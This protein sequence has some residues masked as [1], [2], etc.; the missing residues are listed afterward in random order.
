MSDP[1]RTAAQAEMF[2]NRLRKRFRHLRRWA[3]REGI[4]CFR[5]YDREIPE[6]PI[7]VDWY[8]GR[9]H[10]SVFVG[11]AAIHDAAWVD[12]M[13]ATAGEVLE[14]PPEARFA[15]IRRPQ[16]KGEQGQYERVGERG[17][18]FVVREAG[19]AFRVNLSDYVDTGLFLDH[20]RLRARV[21]DEA[22]GRDMLN[23]FAY[24]GGFSVY[25]AAGGARSTT[26]V[27]LSNTYLDWAR[28][29]LE[30]NGFRG[31][32]HQFVRA[33]VEEFVTH[34]AERQFDLVVVDPPTFSNSKRMR[35]VLDLRRDHPAL[36]AHVI[37]LVRPGGVVYF[38]TNARRFRLEAPA[39]AA[40]E[41]TAETVSPDFTRHHSH[42]AW[43]ITRD[44]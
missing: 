44:V 17:A 24:T 20:R 27:D 16:R 34:S 43:R 10:L 7:A 41:I 22:S 36:L 15:K 6:L 26:T 13:L 23:L 11:D 1:S 5:V 2:H 12:V 3:R 4:V 32:A 21:R 14:V 28:D 18:Q 8:D 39:L 31:R 25:A 35:G 30:L 33:D 29:N 37:R 40:S 38:S 19:L 9:L 42:R